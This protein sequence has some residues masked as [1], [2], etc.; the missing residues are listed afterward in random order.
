MNRFSNVFVFKPAKAGLSKAV[1]VTTETS[2]ELFICTDYDEKEKALIREIKNTTKE[3]YR[4]Y[5]LSD[6]STVLINERR[7]YRIR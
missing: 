6:G 3:P 1:Q 7:L 2:V 5:R 4:Q